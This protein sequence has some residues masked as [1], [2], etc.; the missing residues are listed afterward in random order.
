[1]KL[2]QEDR[3][4]LAEMLAMEGSARILDSVIGYLAA[5]LESDVLKCTSEDANRLLLLK[6]R[7]EGA[8]KLQRLFATQI[9]RLKHD[10]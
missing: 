7:A 2:S 5:D 4:K 6:A 1:M 9:L 8:R 3:E 10:A